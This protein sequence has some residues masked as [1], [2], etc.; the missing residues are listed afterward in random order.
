[1]R[2]APTPGRRLCTLTIYS[3]TWCFPRPIYKV[4]DG[5]NN[6]LTA[7][8]MEKKS[9]HSVNIPQITIIEETLAPSDSL[10]KILIPDYKLFVGPQTPGLDTSE[11][12]IVPPSPKLSN[13]FQISYPTTLC[14]RSKHPNQGTGLSSLSLLNAN[15][16]S[17]S[18]SFC[19]R[20]CSNATFSSTE[21][22]EN[23]L[24]PDSSRLR[25]V[26]SNATFVT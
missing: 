26:D 12:S 14:L 11:S 21:S 24:H 18:S 1:M 15:R 19:H 17:T 9:R 6:C 8:T 25:H 23:D 16:P 7:K 5:G 10:L 13:H 2:G 3:I 20:K 4:C 22:E